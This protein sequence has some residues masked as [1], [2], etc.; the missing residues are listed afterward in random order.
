VRAR[1]EAGSLSQEA[2]SIQ[3]AGKPDNAPEMR[4][5]ASG[6]AT[7]KANDSTAD[8]VYDDPGPPS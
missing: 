8:S 3:V 4:E 7:E 6:S 5:A 2:A 1:H